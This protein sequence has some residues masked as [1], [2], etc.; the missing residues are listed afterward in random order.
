MYA[1]TAEDS[2]APLPR[3][4]GPGVEIVLMETFAGLSLA[5]TY[6]PVNATGPA[7]GLA[8][9]ARNNA[10]TDIRVARISLGI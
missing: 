4:R 10:I 9:D 8:H 7:V 5:S 6:S 2:P 1:T 3:Y